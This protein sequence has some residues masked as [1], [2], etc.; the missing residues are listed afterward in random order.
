MEVEPQVQSSVSVSF[1]AGL[2]I[3]MTSQKKAAIQSAFP[4]WP[5]CQI[6]STLSI[7]AKVIY[8]LGRHPVKVNNGIRKSR[9]LF[10]LLFVGRA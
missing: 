4:V 5:L 7:Y 10:R 3:R 9:A 2:P 8:L 6:P 1:N